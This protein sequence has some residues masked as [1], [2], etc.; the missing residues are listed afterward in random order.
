MRGLTVGFGCPWPHDL[1]S[2]RL[3]RH[4]PCGPRPPFV[5]PWVPAPD[6]SSIIRACSGVIASR[7]RVEGRTYPPALHLAVGVGKAL[8]GALAG[9]LLDD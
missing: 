1:S 5:L 4:H 6:P 8:A 3:I 7:V 2:A 9:V